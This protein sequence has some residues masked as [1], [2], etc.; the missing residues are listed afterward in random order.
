M[1]W[2]AKYDAEQSKR[3]DTPDW[4]RGAAT[5]PARR[6]ASRQL[7]G[8]RAPASQLRLRSR[9][10]I[11][12]YCAS[13][14]GPEIDAMPAVHAG[15]AAMGQRRDAWR[16]LQSG[17]DTSSAIIPAVSAIPPS[18]VD[19]SIAPHRAI[20]CRVHL[21]HAEHDVRRPACLPMAL[22]ASARAARHRLTPPADELRRH[23]MAIE[24]EILS[25]RDMTFDVNI[26]PDAAEFMSLRAGEIS[27]GLG[28]GE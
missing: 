8:R 28:C 25:P 9:F 11:W 1:S 16:E 13:G 19:N 22:R 12:F 15:A 4:P 20:T 2:R 23:R 7:L 3:R 26:K 17:A 10:A 18:E 14:H 27:R 6:P 24:G 5:A 21:S